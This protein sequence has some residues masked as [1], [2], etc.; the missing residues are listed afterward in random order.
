M[1]Q[2]NPI[3]VDLPTLMSV[4]PKPDCPDTFLGEP[5]NY[6]LIGIYGGHFVGQALAAG[7]A[8]IEN[9]KLAQSLHCYFLKTGNPAEPIK[10]RVERLRDGRASST[11]SITGYQAGDRVFHMTAAF[12]LPEPGE[13]HQKSAPEVI[14]HDELAEKQASRG[15]QFKPPM[16]V[17]DRAELLLISEHFV[18][19]QFEPGR[20]PELACWMRSSHKGSI[21]AQSAQC[22]LA[23][24]SD[25]FLMFNSVLPY[26]IPF[27]THR[28]TSLDHSVWFHRACAVEDWMLYDQR[29]IAAV[30]GRGLNEGEVFDANGT[31]ICST[32]QESMLRKI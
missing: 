27:Q 18:T 22:V 10:Y 3:S 19:P 13:T 16:L 14:G 29:S 26:G 5:E 7:F 8:T 6:G 31:L 20:T 24:L 15:K 9:G 32:R 12:K 2:I 17:G 23:F 11:R 30:D 1:N 21:S 28:L 25:G 4:I